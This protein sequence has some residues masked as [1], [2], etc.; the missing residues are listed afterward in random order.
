MKLRIFALAFSAGFI[1]CI[2]AAAFFVFNFYGPKTEETLPEKEN[3]AAFLETEYA[4][5]LL[6][7]EEN[8]KFGPFALINFDARAGRIPVFAFSEKAAV[9]YGGTTVAAGDLCA[10]VSPGIFAGAVETNFGIELSG[11]FIWNREAAEA[12]IAKTGTFD[13]I[14]QKDICYSKDTSYVNLL[15]GVQNM[16]GKKICDIILCPKFSEAE[17]CDMLSRMG[18]AFFNRRLR[19]FLPGSSVYS[20]IFNYMETDISAFDKERYAKLAKVLSDSGESL[21]HHVIN[22]AERDGA[23]GLFRFSDETKTRVKKYFT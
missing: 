10:E 15:S 19:R 12:V 23:A 9:D 20:T 13:Y 21:S 11:Y 1:F 18:A 22:D 14:L 8:G 5:F 6:I 2:S 17:R 7:F 16:T 4:N 3:N